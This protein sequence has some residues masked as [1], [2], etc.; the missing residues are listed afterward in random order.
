MNPKFSIIVPIYNVGKYLKQ[1]LE[2]LVNQE[3]TNYEIIL[4]DDGSPDDCP[5]ICD[6]YASQYS[7]IQVI[8]KKNGGL[9]SARKAGALLSKGKYICC[10]DGDDFISNNYIGILSE[11]VDTY[12]PDVICFDY[13][14][15]SSE[16]CTKA[17]SNKNI[18]PGLYDKQMISKTVFPKL[19]ADVN[20]TYFLPT[21]W[22]KVCKRQLYLPN[23]MSVDDEITMGEDGACTIPIM[24]QADTV[25]FCSQPL[26]YYRLNNE[27]MTKG[28]KRYDWKNQLLIANRLYSIIDS[29]EFDFQDQINR[30]IAR[31]FFNT[32]KSQFNQKTGY[33]TVK[34]DIITHIN[35]PVFEKAINNCHF[36]SGFKMKLIEFCLKKRCVFL[37]YLLNL[38]SA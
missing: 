17:N 30:R 20:G 36:N 2:S 38:I 9:V 35:E 22:S 29:S 34:K 18:D 31:G 15:Y 32:A 33:R 26:Y 21:V 19:I 28:R 7:F 1:C 4:V 27:S 14:K 12:N 11:L 6:E 23:Q 13:Y 3:E 10:V 5:A 25:Y 8:H 37:I 24:Y 16:M